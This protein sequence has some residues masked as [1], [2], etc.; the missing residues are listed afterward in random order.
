MPWTVYMHTCPNGKKYIG[1]TSKS[2]EQRWRNGEGYRKQAF[3]KAI[4]KYGW[5]NISH[6]ILGVV[7]TA[8]EA[9]LEETKYI[10]QYKTYLRKY[11]YNV[12]S[13]TV[14]VDGTPVPRCFEDV[15]RRFVAER[16]RRFRKSR[17]MPQWLKDLTANPARERSPESRKRTGAGL[18]SFQ[19]AKAVV[20]VQFD[21]EWN[22]V[23][24]WEGLSHLK[25]S[26][27]INP[28]ASLYGKGGLSG[29]FHWKHGTECTSEEMLRMLKEGTP[30]HLLTKEV[31]P[32][33]I[34][35]AKLDV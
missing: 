26:T 20:V 9:A 25:K 22:P 30:V 33:N 32:L 31:V 23:A 17:A 13:S 4:R 6:E 29:G 8:E 11:G 15:A 7:D 3:F 19:R 27:G 12:A 2:P 14:I 21:R 35:G 16:N 28:Y 5:K 24:I 1:I 10:A 18:L 34:S